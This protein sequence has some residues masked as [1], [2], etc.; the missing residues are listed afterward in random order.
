MPIKPEDL[1]TGGA[2]QGAVAASL[3]RQR[4]ADD[5]LA[6]GVLIGVFRILREIARGGMAIVYLA[7]RADD[8]YRQQVALKW[9]R[10]IRDDGVASALFLRER[11]ALADLRHPGI[12]RLLD[13]GRTAEGRPWFAM[14]YIDGE[15]LDRHCHRHA[16]PLEKRLDLFLQV[17]AAA[18][19]A[20][21]RGVLHRDI[22]PGNVLVDSDGRVRLLDFGI[23][24]L[25]GH[26]DLASRAYTPG[27]ASPE[28][29][30]GETLTVASDVFQL[31]C[32]LAACLDERASDPITRATD[33]NATAVRLPE[34]IGIPTPEAVARDMD[35]D[36]L[37]LP[38]GL[39]ADVRAIIERACAR[40]PADR[41][42]TADSLAADITARL[43]QRPVSAR[44]HTPRYLF[45]R[46][47]RRHT[48]ASMVSAMALALVVAGSTWFMVRLKQE[49]DSAE[50]QAKVATSVLDFLEDDLLAAATPELA[51]G[52]ELTV[53][54]ALDLAAANVGTRFADAPVEQGAI[55]TT[56][57][58]LYGRL[59]LL[60]QSEEQAR[61]ALHI[62]ESD[63]TTVEQELAARQA[64]IN[65]LLEQGRLDQGE[66][67][68]HELIHDRAALRPATAREAIEDA[69]MQAWIQRQR[70]DYLDAGQRYAAVAEQAR[71]TFG[72]DDLSHLNARMHQS[73]AMQMR[74]EHDAALAL[75]MPVH[76]RYRELL[77]E[78]HPRTLIAAH[79]IGVLR[80]HQGQFDEALTGLQE[81]LAARRRVLGDRH[82]ETVVTINETA[83]VLQELGR[84]EQAEALFREALES[85]LA[86]LGE[87]HQYTR[88]S[89]NNLGLLYIVSRRPDLAAP[90]YERAL[91]IDLRVVGDQHPETLTLMHN[92]AGLYRSQSRYADALTL[93]DRVV[94][95]AGASASLGGDAWQTGLFRVGRARTLD[96]AGR[97]DQA[98]S[99][100]DQ[101]IDVLEASLGADHPR[102]VRARSM[103]DEMRAGE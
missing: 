37:H 8:E 6:P 31:G 75:L 93:H 62:V 7:E 46:F 38:D 87:E 95:L 21:A 60:A 56:L 72:A 35:S 24:R 76:D 78:R 86:V 97:R 47:L 4:E 23:A 65:V 54:E 44:A 15:H 50:Y 100:M 55:R 16:V 91:A 19:H 90:L 67:L 89:M 69:R 53:R 25:S 12:A 26:D 3:L 36:M 64:L 27:F 66:G 34:T 92:L 1:I 49:R 70:G 45:G 73:E 29:V 94:A 28:Q 14:E 32:L 81:T 43:Q 71:Q 101:A 18:A 22:K 9:V 82:P 79:S 10:Q 57:S 63:G 2:L 68:L 102:S 41:Y 39:D 33:A 77:G 84:H 103:R 88:N 40:D 85:R 42:A 5:E 48:L 30:R 96:Q 58:R 80:R 61:Q 52:R 11:Q 98:L 13:G 74:G 51:M 20:H 59:G 99:E 17:C 83:T